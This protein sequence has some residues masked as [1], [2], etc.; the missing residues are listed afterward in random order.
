MA[1]VTA[2]QA[3]EE[4]SILSTRSIINLKITIML[5]IIFIILQLLVAFVMIWYF[6]NLYYSEN[7][8]LW[9]PGPSNKVPFKMFHVYGIFLMAL[10]PYI[11]LII[12]LG[13]LIHYV[14]VSDYELKEDNKVI[15]KI[16]NYFNKVI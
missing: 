4:S 10:I 11:G 12:F 6:K 15:N 3:E 9:H 7:Y 5:W 14:F 8:M 16:I 13:I 2:F 1:N